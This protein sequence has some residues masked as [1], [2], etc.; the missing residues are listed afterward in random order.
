MSESNYG[1]STTNI[2]R[3]ASNL[4]A[5]VSEIASRAQERVSDAA[6]RAQDVASDAASRVQEKASN[7]ATRVQEKAS[8]YS[9]RAAEK[10]GATADYFRGHEMEEVMSDLRGYVKSNPT[11]ALLGAAALG[12]MAALLVRR[13]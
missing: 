10:L 3:D 8:E 5:N 2:R 6:S 4:S 7:V 9:H 11:K 1:P 12:F 13:S